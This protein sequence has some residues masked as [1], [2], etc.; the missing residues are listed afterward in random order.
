MADKRE[1]FSRLFSLGAAS[2]AVGTLSLSVAAQAQMPAQIL[3]KPA[4][5]QCQTGRRTQIILHGVAF[6]PHSDRL[7]PGATAVL[8][9]AAGL[10]K[11]NPC[12]SVYVETAARDAQDLS[13]ARAQVIE[14]HLTQDG[15]VPAHLIVAQIQPE[16]APPAPYPRIMAT[17]QPLL[18]Q[19]RS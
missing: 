19:P 4:A 2:L 3:A 6:L 11:Q 13:G 1:F 16:P 17:Q 10:V 14:A 12:A 15:V 9:D 8:D 18:L 5:P 7:A